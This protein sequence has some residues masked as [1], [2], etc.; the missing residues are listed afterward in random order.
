MSL[1]GRK[2]RRCGFSD[3]RA[4]QI[5][6]CG[7]SGVKESREL[8]SYR[9]YRKVLACGGKGYQLL[10]ANCN[11]IKR[12]E[13]NEHKNGS[14][15]LRGINTSDGFRRLTPEEQEENRAKNGKY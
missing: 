15:P 10:C 9:L 11:W 5:D 14:R 3:E 8:G 2:C 1:L 7:G 6:H 12:H 4:L 13:N